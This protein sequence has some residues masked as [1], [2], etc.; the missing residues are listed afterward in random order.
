M[1]PTQTTPHPAPAGAPAVLALMAKQALLQHLTVCNNLLA[2]ARK[3][4]D[5]L[6]N[7][8]P[9]PAASLQAERKALL[10]RLESALNGLVEKRTLWQQTGMEAVARDPQVARSL[11]LCLDTIMRVL[12]LDRENEQSLL[13]RGLLPPRS[14]PPAEQARPHYVANLYQRCAQRPSR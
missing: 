13:R 12:V 5:A 4:A 11:Q 2:L 1:T 7:P 6:Q 14:L 3:E 10:I 8:A 9:F